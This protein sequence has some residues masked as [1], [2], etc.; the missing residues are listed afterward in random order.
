[1]NTTVNVSTLAKWIKELK[2]KAKRDE[3]F[4]VSWFDETMDK[5]YSIV[6]GWDSGFSD[7]FEDVFCSSKTDPGYVM[8]IKVIKNEGPYAY[9]DFEI[10][11]MPEDKDG[12]VD[13]TCIPLE[14]DDDPEYAAQFFL[15]EWERIMKEHGEE[16]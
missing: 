8:C 7:K 1:M 5:P 3:Q 14:W 9:A 4:L 16:I 13:D 15:G 12:V 2:K 6:G 10:L 11:D